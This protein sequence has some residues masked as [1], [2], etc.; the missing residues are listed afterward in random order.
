M[1]KFLGLVS[2]PDK[3]QRSNNIC[4]NRGWEA[5]GSWG[6]ISVF[7]LLGITRDSFINIFESTGHQ[8]WVGQ[9]GTT[10]SPVA[11]SWWIFWRVL[12]IMLKGGKA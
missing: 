12:I 4:L 11:W 2:V 1:K 9:K 10:R 7:F 5:L 6:S 3:C 8:A